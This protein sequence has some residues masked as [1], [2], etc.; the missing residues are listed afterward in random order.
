MFKL[1]A[2]FVVENNHY[3]EFTPQE[4][5][6]AIPRLSDRAAAYGIPG[7]TVNGMDMLAVYAATHE[8][9]ERARRGDGPSLIEADTYRF[10]NHTGTSEGDPRPEE[11]RAAW[12]ERDPIDALRGVL[13]Q[14]AILSGEGAELVLDEVR[15]E[16]EEA[17]RFAEDSPDPQL[18]ELLTDV[19][20]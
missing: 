9:A 18:S 14:R 17:V 10:Y 2:I 3:G 20:S 1:P 15:R 12:R 5:Q 13:E 6:G 4:R 8:A 16:I 19:Y 7:V 11:Q